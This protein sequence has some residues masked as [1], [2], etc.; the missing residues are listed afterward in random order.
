[1]V[2]NMSNTF[3]TWYCRDILVLRPT[4]YPTEAELCR[5]KGTNPSAHGCNPRNQ[6]ELRMSKWLAPV[7]LIRHNS[8]ST[9]AL[10]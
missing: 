5:C 9:S 2:A 3:F 8:G 6:S 4:V 1:M 10:L 7:S